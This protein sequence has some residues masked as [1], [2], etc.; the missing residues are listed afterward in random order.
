MALLLKAEEIKGLI[1][2]EEAIGAVESGFRDQ[3]RYPR[4]S[5]PRQRMTA[6]DRRINIHSGGVVGLGV[7]GTFIHYERHR[8]TEKD[9]SYAAAGKR[10][11]LA[12]DSESAALLTV[13]VGSIPLY[14]FDDN[15][16]ATETA[17]T[18]AV[19]TKQLAR[20]N[21]GV[22]GLYGTGR[23]ARRHLKVMCALRP[24]RKVKVFSRSAEHRSAFCA[25]MQAHVDA[26]L[27][28]VGDPREAARGSDLIVCATGSN[29]PVLYGEWLEPG[30]H[31]TSIVGSNKELVEEGL[32]ARPRREL[33][34]EV[35]KRADVIVATLRQ[36]GIYDEQGDFIEP[37]AQGVLRWEDIVDLGALLAGD[38]PGRANEKQITLF[39]QNSDQGVG[40][41]ALARLAHDKARAAGIGMEI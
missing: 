23:Q 35:L 31:V 40:F 36:Q 15:D 32:V 12:Y 39:K 13:I 1:S 38:A 22:M 18:S 28:P 7:A 5:L 29:V 17:I 20:S 34:D 41:M 8:F 26:E 37:I 24:I 4:F 16:I 19:G 2:I 6:G 30:Q 27:V 11:Y 21:C 10:V 9:Q 33:D 14:E 25:L 3:A